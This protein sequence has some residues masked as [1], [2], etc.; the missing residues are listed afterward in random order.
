MLDYHDSEWGYPVADD[1]RLFEKLSLEAFQAGLSWRTVLNKRENFR[2]AFAGFDFDRVAGFGERDVL[3]LLQDAGI[4]RHR[5][6]IEA[7]INN[8]GRALELIERE[9]SLAAFVW[10]YEPDAASLGPPLSAS[11]SPESVALSKELKRR[12]WRFVGPTTMFAFMQAMGLVNDHVEGCFV[13]GQVARARDGFA[14]PG[15]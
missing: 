9:G 10:S 2:S 12:G 7:V 13:R 6:K 8:A 11:T 5:G 15:P 3:R 1:R 14:R 4:I